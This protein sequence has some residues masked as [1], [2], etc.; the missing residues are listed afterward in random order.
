MKENQETITLLS[1]IHNE[2]RKQN[3]IVKTVNRME[4][5][6]E[7]KTVQS[8]CIAISFHN[9]GNAVVTIDSSYTLAP[10]DYVSFGTEKGFLDTTV[11]RI[12]FGT[13]TNKNLVV[14][15]TYPLPC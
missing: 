14:V 6:T 15:R 5:V 10:G 7:N 2:L 12:A 13:G 9:Q 11:Y 3:S 8:E 1:A 4:N